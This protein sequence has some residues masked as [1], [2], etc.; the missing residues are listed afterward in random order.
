MN[1][2][3]HPVTISPIKDCLFTLDDQIRQIHWYLQNFEY[4]FVSEYDVKDRLH[5][6]GVV[7]LFPHQISTVQFTLTRNIGFTLIKNDNPGIAWYCYMFKD[8]DKNGRLISSKIKSNNVL[9]Y[10]SIYEE[11]EQIH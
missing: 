10:P 9:E 6:H 4:V 2:N 3:S 5:W 7:K 1:A 11:R 8:Y